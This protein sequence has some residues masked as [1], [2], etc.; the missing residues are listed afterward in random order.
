[1]IIDVWGLDIEKYFNEQFHRYINSDN[2]KNRIRKTIFRKRLFKLAILLLIMFSIIQFSISILFVL[3]TYFEY[4]NF[5]PLVDILFYVIFVTLVSTLIGFAPYGVIKMVYVNN[6][7]DGLDQLLKSA[8]RDVFISL[9]EVFELEVD[10]KL[11]FKIKI[12]S[13]E[14]KSLKAIFKDYYWIVRVLI[15]IFILFSFKS[16]VQLYFIDINIYSN[17]YI[18]SYCITFSCVIV[19]WLVY[20]INL[21]SSKGKVDGNKSIVYTFEINKQ[22]RRCKAFGHLAM[23]NEVLRYLLN[24]SSYDVI[25]VN[26][27]KTYLDEL[28]ELIPYELLGIS[29]QYKTDIY[30]LNTILMSPVKDALEIC[31]E[32]LRAESE[33]ENRLILENEFIFKSFE[34]ITTMN[35]DS[36]K[37]N[38]YEEFFSNLNLS[39]GDEYGR[40][41]DFRVKNIG[42]DIK[43]RTNKLYK[44]LSFLVNEKYTFLDTLRYFTPVVNDNKVFGLSGFT[45]IYNSENLDDYFL[46]K[47]VYRGV[48]CYGFV[49]SDKQTVMEK[50][51][52]TH[53]ILKGEFKEQ[54]F[55]ENLLILNSEV[56]NIIEEYIDCFS[57]DVECDRETREYYVCK[58]KKYSRT[59][60]DDECSIRIDEYGSMYIKNSY[61]LYP[62]VNEEVLNKY[63]LVGITNYAIDE[64]VVKELNYDMFLFNDEIYNLI[65]RFE[66]LKLVK[67]NLGYSKNRKPKNKKYV[68]A[69]MYK[70][71]V[72]EFSGLH[73]VNNNSYAGNQRTM[74]IMNNVLIAKRIITLLLIITIVVFS[75][76][77]ASN[78][79]T[80]FVNIERMNITDSVRGKLFYIMP[81]LMFISIYNYS[82]RLIFSPKSYISNGVVVQKLGKFISKKFEKEFKVCDEPIRLSVFEDKVLFEIPIEDRGKYIDNQL[83]YNGGSFRLYEMKLDLSKAIMRKNKLYHDINEVYYKNN[84]SWKSV[85]E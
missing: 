52:D 19:I 9:K 62:C 75:I 67:H 23:R 31:A 59:V 24:H 70:M 80:N 36:I 29:N 42:N 65:C 41:C 10:A 22:V 7:F 27:Y 54:L 38:Y 58:P 34:T 49:L 11:D 30:S 21:Y 53:Y 46:K 32:F 2:C 26:N 78:L 37:N 43:F 63:S 71:N 82:K 16:L 84:E 15:P 33:T 45:S 39:T 47:G 4:N 14:E 51:S 55:Y 85:I 8:R 73:L 50:I 61:L 18:I 77:Y 40:L 57:I 79:F 12:Y 17:I 69:K 48:N 1:M 5:I 44:G 64:Y 68:N 81:L 13:D 60:I 28:V 25:N 6:K 66:S 74:Q 72:N 35:A 20:T 83:Y 56:K 3:D 76:F